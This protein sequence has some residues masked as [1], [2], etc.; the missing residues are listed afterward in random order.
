MSFP[1]LD[2]YACWDTRRA[3][4]TT[5]CADNVDR[6]LDQLQNRKEHLKFTSCRIPRRFSTYVYTI[7]TR[8]VTLD[9]VN[10]LLRPSIRPIDYNITPWLRPP[11]ARYTPIRGQVNAAKIESGVN[12][13]PSAGLQPWALTFSGWSGYM[14]TQLCPV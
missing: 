6:H 9:V 13:A 5:T 4:G 14:T 10:L 2:I 3:A 8:R 11:P 7:N 1:G 12:L